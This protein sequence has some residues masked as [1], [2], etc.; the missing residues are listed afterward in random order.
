MALPLAAFAKLATEVLK[1]AN[2]A[3]EVGA[4]IVTEIQ[5]SKRLI[6][7][8]DR[9]T[10]VSSD[11]VKIEHIQSEVTKSVLNNDLEKHK[12]DHKK[13]ETDQ[14][15]GMIVYISELKLREKE[16]QLREEEILQG[17]IESVQKKIRERNLLIL[18]STNKAVRPSDKE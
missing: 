10:A 17:R 7:D 18:D 6:S 4:R 13:F 11:S 3:A 15:N 8:N 9:I 14:K 5:E 16:L 2:K 1:T 12:I